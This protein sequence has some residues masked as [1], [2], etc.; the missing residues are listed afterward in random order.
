[1]INERYFKPVNFNRCFLGVKKEKMTVCKV[2][3]WI[4]HK[5][6]AV[7]DFCD[8]EILLDQGNKMKMKY[9]V[10]ALHCNFIAFLFNG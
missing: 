5:L 9:Y 8:G 10:L 4:P 7:L 2:L 1:M 6:Y 3:S